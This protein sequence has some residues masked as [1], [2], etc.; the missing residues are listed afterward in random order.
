MPL[1]KA[2][3]RRGRDAAASRTQGPLEE[4]GEPKPMAPRTMA[5]ILRPDAPRLEGLVALW[6]ARR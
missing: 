2:Y 4:V 6:C 5:E 3:F 1:S